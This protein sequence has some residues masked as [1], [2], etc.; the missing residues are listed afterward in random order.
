MKKCSLF[1]ILIALAFGF[2]AS[3][4]DDES[5]E[6]EISES[7]DPGME[8]EEGPVVGTSLD[9]TADSPSPRIVESA[10]EAPRG[11][12]RP[13]GPKKGGAIQ[14]P[15]PGAAQGLIR[16]NKDGSY[17]YK[18]GEKDKNQALSFRV[19]STTPPKITGPGN[20]GFADVY[21]KSSLV[22]ILGDYEWQP[23]RR[24]GA[25]GI[26]LG[27][28]L[29]MTRGNGR[30]ANLEV[31]R[32]AYDFFVI[33][34]SAFLV[35][36][37]EYMRHQWFVPYINGGG[38]MYGLVEKRDDSKPAQFATAQAVGFGGGIHISISRWDPQGAFIMQKEYGVADLWL[39]L[40]ARI[41]QGLPRNDIDFT[42][43][44]ASL[45]VTVDY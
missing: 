13:P 15:H 32:E 17:Q 6:S 16:I 9:P 25:L 4:Q 43:Q 22:G 14:V 39:T 2:Q 37:F 21:G 42:N 18:T 1:L 34:L 12:T 5:F 8:A 19:S 30:F 31:A 33:P 28:G 27:S 26:Q 10:P 7:Y 23:F 40:E 24:F 3:A 38:T 44:T 36:R 20:I 41:T 11:F 35:Y 29:I 45:G